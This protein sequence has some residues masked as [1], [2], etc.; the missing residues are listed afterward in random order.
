MQ[1]LGEWQALLHQQRDCYY[2]ADTE[3]VYQ[4]Q[5]EHWFITM[6]SPSQTVCQTR[7]LSKSAY[8]PS[9][10][11]HTETLPEKTISATVLPLSGPTDS[12][13]VSYSNT[14]LIPVA[15]SVNQNEHYI[16]VDGVK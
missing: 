11:I 1:P 2:Q 16:I 3:A 8:L 13:V 14:P 4:W 5:N 10:R 9:Y 7:S 15:V 12:Y 6:P